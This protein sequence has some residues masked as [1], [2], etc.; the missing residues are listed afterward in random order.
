VPQ[1]FERASEL[2]H[3]KE[4]DVK[5]LYSSTGWNECRRVVGERV[6]EERLLN[7]LISGPNERRS[8]PYSAPSR[9]DHKLARGEPQG[10]SRAG[11][12]LFRLHHVDSVPMGIRRFLHEFKAAL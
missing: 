2:T 10:S 3:R 1:K 4:S 12:K 11:M 6:A 5:K 7:Q 9:N 8:V